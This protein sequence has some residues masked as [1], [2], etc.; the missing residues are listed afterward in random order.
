ME[1]VHS[2]E[3]NYRCL[4][5]IR[6]PTRQSGYGSEGWAIFTNGATHV[7]DEETMAGWGA[8]VRSPHGVSYIVFGPVTTAEAHVA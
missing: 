8:V 6:T 7:N 3:A 2:V 1:G 5:N 4:P